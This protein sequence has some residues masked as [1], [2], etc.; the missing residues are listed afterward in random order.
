[1]AALSG[2]ALSI[3]SSSRGRA[4]S[5]G[6]GPIRPRSRAGPRRP[7]DGG[8]RRRGERARARARASPPSADLAAPPVD[9]RQP[10]EQARR[11]SSRLRRP[12]RWAARGYLVR[13]V[14]DAALAADERP[15]SV[16]ARRAAIALRASP[17]SSAAATRRVRTLRGAVADLEY[18][19]DWSTSRRRPRPQSRGATEE[20]RCGVRIVA[21]ERSP[22]CASQAARR[23][24]REDSLG[25][26]RRELDPVGC[27]C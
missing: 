25:S 1:M 10:D 6:S 14:V 19:S 5:I 9:V 12:R 27:A 23:H 20:I 26:R 15:I 8:G 4:R 13:D 2:A 3:S 24:E 17:A 16:E 21:G 22:S 7:T 11:P 18:A